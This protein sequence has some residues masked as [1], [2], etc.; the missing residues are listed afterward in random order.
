MAAMRPR[1]LLLFTYS[2][3]ISVTV[4]RWHCQETYDFIGLISTGPTGSAFAGTT[5]GGLADRLGSGG[6]FMTA[7]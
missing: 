2:A 7:A 1:D 3:A 6:Q 4:V 5:S